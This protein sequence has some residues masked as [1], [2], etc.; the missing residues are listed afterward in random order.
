MSSN[1]AGTGIS[2]LTTGVEARRVYS[3]L[4]NGKVQQTTITSGAS[5]RQSLTASLVTS[6]PLASVTWKDG[7]EIRVYYLDSNYD[8]H[9][10]RYTEGRGWSEGQVSVTARSAPGAGLAATFYE[11]GGN[12]H[13]R[14]Y[15]QEVDTGLIKEIINTGGLDNNWSAGTLK[16]PGSLANTSLAAVTYKSQNQAKTHVFYQALDLTLKDHVNDY[17]G[18][19]PG[20]FKQGVA[21]S[22]TPLSSI[23]YPG[24]NATTEVQVYWR[25]INGD[26][27]FAKNAGAPVLIQPKIGPA[28]QLSVVQWQDGQA[29]RVYYQKFS[30]TLAEFY[31]DDSGLTWA[32]GLD[33][34]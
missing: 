19:N 22:K 14:V 10:Y 26:V 15:Y 27:V 4:N 6:S 9:E 30:G 7:K 8:V 17:S 5:T 12:V 31:S 29:L 13:I 24:R 21:T 1:I 2:A 11:G 32:A 28:Y 18:W 3:Q 33:P 25:D 16:L 20:N 34:I 23:S